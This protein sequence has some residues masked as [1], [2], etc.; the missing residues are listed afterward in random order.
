MWHNSSLKP[1]LFWFDGSMFSFVVI[2]SI[3]ATKITFSILFA[4]AVALKILDRR[5]ITLRIMFYTVRR[6]IV[7][8]YRAVPI[9]LRTYRRRARW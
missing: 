6:C 8:N 2:F 5:G 9:S 3:H 1:K 4:V 7:G